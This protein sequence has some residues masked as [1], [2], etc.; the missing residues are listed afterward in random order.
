MSNPDKLEYYSIIRLFD[1]EFLYQILNN[2]ST[3][4]K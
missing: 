4:I 2:D 1:T 3:L